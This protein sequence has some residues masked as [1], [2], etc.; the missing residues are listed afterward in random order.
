MDRVKCM[1]DTA[2]SWPFEGQMPV[3]QALVN[4]GHMSR[5]SKTVTFCSS[6]SSSASTVNYFPHLWQNITIHLIQFSPFV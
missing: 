3:D 5:D 1:I 4:H 6:F 2:A